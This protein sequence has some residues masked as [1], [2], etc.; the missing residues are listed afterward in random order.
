MTYDHI[1]VGAGSAGAILASRLTEDAARSV[2]L[3]EAGPDFSDI[4]DL[5]PDVKW[6]YGHGMKP[7]DTLGADHRWYFVAKSTDQGPP[8][9]VPRGKTTGGS[10]AVNAQIFL[11]GVP[12]DY[13][14]W[15]SWGNDEWDF[16]KLMPYFRRMESDTDFS[17]DFHGID[18]PTIVRRFKADQWLPEQRGW[19]EATREYGFADC[20]DHN[21]PDSTGVGPCPFN[22][23]NRIRWSTNIGYLNPAR[24]RPNLTVLS[25]ALAHRVI[26]E[27]RKAVGVEVGVEGEAQTLLGGEVILSSGAIGSPHLLM[28]SGV[29]PAAHLEGMGVEVVHDSPGVGQN[30]RD[31]PQVQLLWKTKDGFPHDVT[32]P[33]I[34]FILRYTS[35]GSNLRNDM[36]IHPIS[37]ARPSWYYTES[38]DWRPVGIGMIAAIYLAESAGEMRLRSTD[39]RIQPYLD[40]NL[41][42]TEFDRNRLR[43]AVHICLELVQNET[44]A[45]M[46]E[47]RLDPTDGDLASDDTLD[48]WMMRNVRTSHHISSTCKMGPDSDSMAVVDQYARVRGLEGLRVADASIMPD[49]IRANTNAT[50]MIIGERVSDFI[51]GIDES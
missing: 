29:G 49:C 10:S 15:A 17:D 26:F 48:D 21:D 1:I 46:I 27:G 45:D 5:P 31:H 28:L 41:L 25:E 50:S 32:G 14:D 8:M 33:G 35:E 22:N 3:I 51:R 16:R 44:L 4:D 39:P 7:K 24:D 37:L 6:G 43:E 40:Y 19:Y 9:L 23:P 11:R 38:D 20:P 13:D 30:L 34:Q 12:E 18:G 47:T 2:L 42:A 36:L